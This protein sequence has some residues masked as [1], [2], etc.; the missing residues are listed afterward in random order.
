MASVW[1]ADS[2]ASKRPQAL[3]GPPV[4]MALYPFF[5]SSPSVV[6]ALVRFRV[7]FAL[8]RYIVP[9]HF[10]EQLANL[11]FLYDLK[12][13]NKIFQADASYAAPKA[14]KRLES[15]FPYYLRGE[16]S[17]TL[18]LQMVV[19]ALIY[20]ARALVA[21]AFAFHTAVAMILTFTS[22]VVLGVS[23]GL[24]SLATASDTAAKGSDD[25]G[26]FILLSFLARILEGL[27][28]LASFVL[29]PISMGAKLAAHV[30]GTYKDPTNWQARSAYWAVRILS[31]VVAIAIAYIFTVVIPV[32]PFMMALL[33]TSKAFGVIV[34]ILSLGL[35][36]VAF[37]SAIHNLVSVAVYG[38]IPLIFKSFSASSVHAESSAA[39]AMAVMYD[40]NDNRQDLVEAQIITQ[41]MENTIDDIDK[42]I[43]KDRDV[44]IGNSSNNNNS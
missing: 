33:A 44:S 9:L 26:G 27:T 42:A 18:G 36:H 5:E 8:S 6:T 25:K 19:A 16:F 2:K 4:A 7:L 20:T 43:S 35:N 15:I 3:L 13:N 22:D 41:G 40:V 23:S 38:F 11:F 17:V 1:F 24:H 12:K 14:R 21:I 30:Q 34:T 29:A 28:L 32:I 31:L 10:V 37:F 39:L